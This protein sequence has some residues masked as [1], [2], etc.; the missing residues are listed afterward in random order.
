VK[1]VLFSDLHLDAAFAWLGADR[2]LARRRRQAVRDALVR[3]VELA[4]TEEADALICG[5]DLYEQDRFTPDTAAFLRGVFGNAA[6]L[7]IYISPGNHDWFGPESLYR[8]VDWSSNVHIF[9]DAELQPVA[10]ADGLT[11][12]GAS[13][14]APAN[15][16]GFLDGF[17][18]DRSGVHLALF[19]G[20]E[21][22][23]FLGQEEGK[24]PH[25]PFRAAQI[26]EAGIHHAFLG[27]FHT[28]SDAPRYTYPGNPEP[29]S[30]GETGLRGAVIA[31]INE[32]G[33]VKRVRQ[34]VGI[35]VVHDLS[36][37][38]TGASSQ[39]D[40]RTSI[41]QKTAN[42]SG[43]ARIT[44][45]GELAPAIDLRVQDLADAAPS[46]EACQ[47]RLGAIQLGYDL[48]SIEKELT[49][50]GQFVKDVRSAALSDE[51]RQRVLLAGLRALD[52]RS[53]L[54]LI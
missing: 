32:D 25:A 27:H 46:F 40:V 37:D 44:I 13:H 33:S 3:I 38:L 16:D 4:K 51:V 53:D 11:L 28:P 49:V 9:Q 36:V 17:R 2:P 10:L 6:P 45:N 41:A 18:V 34:R 23:S 43:I 50:R 22:G 42:L 15:T 7:P 14:R 54:E 19:H 21:M 12:W 29:L 8:Q 47:I 5:G 35:T 1:L 30:F 39:Q 52:R 31:T 20:S 24:Q 26:E 48:A